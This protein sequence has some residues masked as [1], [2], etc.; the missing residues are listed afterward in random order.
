MQET[1]LLKSI[2]GEKKANETQLAIPTITTSRFVLERRLGMML[3]A[4]WRLLQYDR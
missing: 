1:V 4:Q 2:M 3:S